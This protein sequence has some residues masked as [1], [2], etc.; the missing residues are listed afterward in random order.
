MLVCL[1]PVASQAASSFSPEQ[2]QE[3][4]AIVRQALKADPSI[5]RDAVEAAQADAAKNQ[6]AAARAAIAAHQ[7]ALSDPADPVAGNPAGSVTIVEFF[8]PRCPYCKAMEPTLRQLLAQDHSVRLVLKDLP[9]LGPPSLLGSKALLAAQK[10]G[11]YLKLRRV[12]MAGS[13]AIT[14]G[15]L[16]DA[17][18]KLGLDWNR[19]QHDMDDPA[20]QKRLD[21]NI[22]LAQALGIEGTP[23]MVIGDDL[24]SGAVDL[25]QLQK[26]VAAA[27]DVSKG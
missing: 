10:Q 23:A 20:I 11:G 15:W 22:R 25:D 19:L 18:T 26:A 24:I 16:H 7:A 5:L 2:R 27:H 17:A 21:A 9:I 6:Q 3:I 8:D 14:M 13:P 1:G 12:M 4:I